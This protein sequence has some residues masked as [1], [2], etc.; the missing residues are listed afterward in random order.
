MDEVKF[1]VVGMRELM[2][3]LHGLAVVTQKRLALGAV[4]TAA[5][6]IRKKSVELA[7]IY[8]GADH[9]LQSLVGRRSVK[10][11]AGHPQPGTLKRSIYQTR[12]S[13]KCT[14]TTEVWKVD[15]RRGKKKTKK[16]AD[17]PDAYYA[18]WVEYGHYTRPPSGGGTL[19]MRRAEGR[20]SGAVKWV[21]AQPFM[22][23]AFESSKE[24]ALSAMAKYIADNLHAAT[25]SF[26]L[27]K[28][29]K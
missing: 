23:P 20:R 9:Y 10:M 16:G 14:P 6:V 5:S 29:I 4:A 21:P 7:P 19:K 26:R 25:L 12:M 22:R 2:E 13:E 28:A 8:L 27:L 24:E 17:Q 18:A 11:S 15:V 1:T 3:E